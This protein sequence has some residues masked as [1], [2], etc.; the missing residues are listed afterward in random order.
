MDTKNEMEPSPLARALEENKAD[1]LDADPLDEFL[2]QLVMLFHDFDREM[3]KHV[4]QQ[5]GYEV[6]SPSG[7]DRRNK[8]YFEHAQYLAGVP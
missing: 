1:W 3:C 7:V 4:W 5:Y 6:Y 8:G 2:A